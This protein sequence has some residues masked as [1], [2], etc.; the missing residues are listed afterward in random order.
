MVSHGMIGH[1]KS[2]LRV[3]LLL[4]SVPAALG[5]VA[6]E[7]TAAEAQAIFAGGCFWCVEADFDKVAGVKRTVSGY[8]GGSGDN[9]T[10]QSH[11]AAGHREAVE[12]TFDDSVIS[13]R[14]LVAIFLRTID[15]T[16]GRGQFCDRGHSYTT[17]IHALD[18]IQ[19]QIAQAELDGAEAVLERRIRTELLGP[20][21]FWPAEED[22][23]DYHL[24]NPAAYLFYRSSCFRDRTVKRIWGDQA[25]R[26]LAP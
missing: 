23:Q 19:A 26:G 13:Y 5:L 6:P 21:P 12:V 15:P 1:V 8:V 17:A 14:E 3:A 25:Y 11:V 9:P 16:D 22:H 10:Y 20:A 4:G 18:D 24:K 7:A 2:A